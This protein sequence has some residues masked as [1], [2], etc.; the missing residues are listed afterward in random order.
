MAQN[1]PVADLIDLFLIDGG[2]TR[3]RTAAPTVNSKGEAV[4]QTPVDT[5]VTDVAIHTATERD[6]QRL[7]EADRRKE[8]IRVY[9]KIDQRTAGDG[10]AADQWLY[11]SKVYEVAEVADYS[12]QGGVWISTALLKES[13]T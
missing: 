1:V 5:V 8:A 3:R 7:P 13:S 6:L 10:A 9:T 4:A 11:D 2:A 12:R